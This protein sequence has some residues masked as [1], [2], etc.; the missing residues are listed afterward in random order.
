M[1]LFLLAS[2]SAQS[3]TGRTDLIKLA[4]SVVMTDARISQWQATVDQFGPDVMSEWE[5]GLYDGA[6]GNHARARQWL[7][8]AAVKGNTPPNDA[9]CLAY[10]LAHGTQRENRDDL[11]GEKKKSDLAVAQVQ[12][13][14]QDAVAKLSSKQPLSAEETAAFAGVEGL[15]DGEEGSKLAHQRIVICRNLSN[16]PSLDKLLRAAHAAGKPLPPYALNYLGAG[17]EEAQRFDDAAAWYARAAQAGLLIAGTN[18]IRLRE[19]VAAPGANDPLW[20][21]LLAGYHAQAKLGDGNAMLLLADA[22][23]RGLGG[24]ADID[25]AIR[26]YQAGIDADLPGNADDR[27]INQSMAYVF[28][29]MHA[30]ERLTEHYQAGRFKLSNDD[31]RKK[32]LSMQ[33]LLKEAFGK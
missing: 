4:D 20:T 24:P 1:S 30:Q 19:R 18:Q 11:F 33:F 25:T 26:L 13:W 22:I 31:Q 7:L 10:K 29:G 28:H 27:E 12:T 17:S 16:A 15:P 9:L 6:I 3:D 21:D 8:Q 14:Y 23:E 2:A 32:Y 5:R